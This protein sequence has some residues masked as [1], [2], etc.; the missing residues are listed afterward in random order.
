MRKITLVTALFLPLWVHATMNITTNEQ[1]SQS[2]KPDV[3]QGSLSFEEQSKNSTTIKEH[4]NLIVAAVKGFD[5]KG[6]FCQGGGYHLSPRYSYKDQ[7]Q[8][9]IGY[10]GNLNFGCEFKAIE[11]YNTLIAK[12][13]KVS[14]PSVR[15]SEGALSWGVSEKT[16]KMVKQS[17]RVELLRSAKAQ[18]EAFSK[19]T[20]LECAVESVNFGGIAQPHPVMMKAM[21]MADSVGTESPIQRDEESSLD[22]TVSYICSKRV[23]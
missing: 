3:L 7:K 20:A 23:P 1:V 11:E 16:Q 19:E 12:I 14:A 9:F 21:M 18:A 17:L 22:A 2:L 8:E 4:L 15:K 13:D 10:S 6:E 5:P